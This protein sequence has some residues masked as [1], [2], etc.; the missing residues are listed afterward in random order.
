MIKDNQKQIVS[1]LFFFFFFIVILIYKDF[2]SEKVY[3]DETHFFNTAILFS[4]EPIPSLNLLK[5]Y[6]ELNT[7]LPFMIGGWSI[8]ILGENIIPLRWMCFLLS[9]L[10]LNLF[11]WVAGNRNPHKIWWCLLGLWL[12]PSYYLC[13]TYFYTDMFALSV[14]LGGMIAYLKR[15]HWL[16]AILFS[17]SIC[18]RQ[19]AVA[20]PLAIL[21]FEAFEILKK[22]QNINGLLNDIFRKIPLFWYVLPV[23]TLLFWGVL[24][25]GFA[26]P[27]EMARQYYDSLASYKFGFVL[28]VSAITA[29]YFVIP[30][31][32]L[33]K[34]I[35]YYWQFP[36]K[37]PALFTIFLLVIGLIVYFSPAKQTYNPYFT[38]P[39]MGYV[40][41]GLSVMGFSYHL[42]QI[43]FGLLMLISL[44]RFISPSMTLISWVFIVNTLL[45]GKAQLSWDKYSLPTMMV[46]W[47][48]VLWEK[49]DSNM[50]GSTEFSVTNQPQNR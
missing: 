16:S 30:E 46:L 44:M 42:K 6:P 31:M 36:Q 39:Y 27:E 40:D 7:P 41:Q 35:T 47:F 14:L 18:S 48:L 34:K 38:W 28:Y 10:I 9:F 5:T 3:Q 49:E 50:L 33:G 32:V 15:R 43:I 12:F 8:N 45:L 22:Y 20:F 4:K 37:S 23:V 13:T 17:I 26:P 19:Y 1:T 21:A 25:G 24:W 29:V 2:F 11:I